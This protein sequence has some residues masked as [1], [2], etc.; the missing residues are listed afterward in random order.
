MRALSR[1]MWVSILICAFGIIAAFVA[2]NNQNAEIQIWPFALFVSAEIWVFI[3]GAFATGMLLG[4]LTFW[5]KILHLRT[6]IWGYQRQIAKFHKKQE[7][8]QP[9]IEDKIDS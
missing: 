7:N 2:V 3:L 9:Q 5:L 6:L 4:G 1:L 8:N